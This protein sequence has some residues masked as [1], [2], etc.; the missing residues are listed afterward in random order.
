MKSIIQLIFLFLTI[1]VLGYSQKS[2]TYEIEVLPK[3]EKLLPQESTQ[4][5]FKDLKT[6]VEKSSIL[7][8][9]LVYFGEHPFLRGVI[10]AYGGHRPL[11]ISP[12]MIWLLINQGFARHITNNAEKFRK[13]FVDFEGKKT[14]EVWTTE[15]MIGNPKSN[16]ESVFP[17]FSKQIKDFTGK[18]LVD[19][20]TSDFS[21]TTITSKIA[22][23]ITI[24]ESVKA[25]FDYRL[26]YIGC[27]IPKITIEGTTEDWEKL[28]QKT[29]YI[30]KY[31]LQW[32]VS[33]LEPVLQEFINAKKGHFNKEFWMNMVQ[34]HTKG[35][36]SPALIDGWV[37]KFFPYTVR[38]KKTNLSSTYLSTIDSLA[39]EIVKVPF[40][41]ID[42]SHNLKYEM[43]FWAGFVGLRQTEKD[44]SLKPEIAWLVSNKSSFNPEY[45]IFKFHKKMDDLSINNV[46]TIPGDIYSIEKI[47]YLK[48]TFL[49][50]IVIPDELAKI[51]IAYLELNGKISIDAEQRIKKLFPATTLMI[52][53]ERK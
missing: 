16:W 1:G 18:E 44:Y 37:M 8:D 29:K 11:I 38:G 19:T 22:S 47:T 53:G 24:M 48:I 12:D 2:T 34:T 6:D 23:Q 25:Y 43:E 10:A 33:E 49:K 39:S 30:S 32:W 14:L 20:L 45:S 28:L 5:I 52:N 9:S 13:D 3:P 31:D 35:S 7:A 36:C 41:F 26:I 27:G 17:Q 15:I 42:K 4:K 50:D 21:T 51:D 40:L 46:D